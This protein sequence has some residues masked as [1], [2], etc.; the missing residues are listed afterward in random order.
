MADPRAAYFASRPSEASFE[1]IFRASGSRSSASVISPRIH[2]GATPPE[3][4][5]SEPP[6]HLGALA[7]DSFL[8]RFEVRLS[9]RLR[10]CQFVVRR[11]CLWLWGILGGFGHRESLGPGFAWSIPACRALFLSRVESLVL[12]LKAVVA[13]LVSALRHRDRH[14]SPHRD[15]PFLR[16]SQVRDMLATRDHLM[17]DGDWRFG[18]VVAAPT[19][20]P[21][22]RPGLVVHEKKAVA[23]LRGRGSP[24]PAARGPLTR[25]PM[26][27]RGL[28]ATART[29]SFT[30]RP[31]TRGLARAS[32]ND[33][34]DCPAHP[35]VRGFAGP[36][37]ERFGRP[38]RSLARSRPGA[39]L[40]RH[41]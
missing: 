33:P 35:Q 13:V 14:Y 8:D 10:R 11:G 17:R 34:V 29:P 15:H 39:V 20:S 25:L 28:W 36:L 1:L 37:G 6:E 19:R 30:A 40:C 32:R 24:A 22:G 26:G 18:T 21:I 2:P 27:A 5:F 16:T 41:M 7:K 4:S 31:P 9:I 23:L 12:G 3:A 38:G